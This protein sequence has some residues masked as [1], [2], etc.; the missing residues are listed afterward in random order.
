MNNLLINEDKVTPESIVALFENALIK[1]LLDEEGDIK[2]TTD[3][4]TVCYPTSRQENNQIFE[5]FQL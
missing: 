5:L 3:M 1:A 4:G 2:V